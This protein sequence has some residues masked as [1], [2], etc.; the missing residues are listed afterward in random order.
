MKSTIGVIRAISFEL[1]EAYHGK[2][3][4]IGGA[5]ISTAYV[6]SK[7]VKT[8]AITADSLETFVKTAHVSPE[9][10]EV[11]SRNLNG[12]W[13]TVLSYNNKF[14]ADALEEV[15]FFENSFFEMSTP[16]TLIELAG[17][18][19]GINEQDKVLD[20]CSGSAAF[21]FMLFRIQSQMNI[22]EWRSILTQTMLPFSEVHSLVTTFHLS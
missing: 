16:V 7:I 2:I 12:L 15:V 6:L 22:Q 5:V 21:L 17:K 1:S 18:I 13:E 4:N 11:L 9:V 8:P 19:L 20:I 10:S 3:S 14:D